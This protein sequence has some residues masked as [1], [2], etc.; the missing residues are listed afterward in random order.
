MTNVREKVFLSICTHNDDKQEHFERLTLQPY[1]IHVDNTA[2]PV[3]YCTGEVGVYEL[4][5]VGREW[6]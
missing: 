1:D 5:V 3:V 2:M 6:G 4:Q